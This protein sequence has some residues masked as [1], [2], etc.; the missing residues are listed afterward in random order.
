MPRIKNI[1]IA[2]GNTG[3]VREIQEIFAAFP[4]RFSSLKDHWRPTPSIPETGAT[5][6]ENARIKAQWVYSRKGMWTLAD[7]SGLE[8]DALGGEPG[9]FSARYAGEGAGDAANNRKLLDKLA[10]VAR[11]GR[12]ARFRC[13]VALV[14]PGGEYLA[15]GIC[16]GRIGFEL[17]GDGGFGYDP[18][19][20]PDG[21][22]RT[23]AELD[24][25]RKHAIS[26][27]G[28]A[29]QSLIGKIREFI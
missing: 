11:N 3:K 13:V 5:F 19:F 16:E 26:H 29:L 12:K 18:L 21:F 8:V 6:E 4:I 17:K 20:I 15:E 1:I 10:S 28:R 27:R 14:G 24:A 7:D 25:A 23:F 22:D 9:V 2:T